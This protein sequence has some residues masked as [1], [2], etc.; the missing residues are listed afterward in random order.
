M[1]CNNVKA[2]SWVYNA[3]ALATWFVVV[4]TTMFMRRHMK[5]FMARRIKWLQEMPAPRSTT[6][7]VEG[8]PDGL[9]KEEALLK[10]FDDSVFARK[11]VKEV[12]VVKDLRHS[13]LGELHKNLEAMNRTIDYR[14]NAPLA[15]PGGS[16]AGEVSLIDLQ[17]TRKALEA[18]I[19][20]QR[21]LYVSDD[22]VNSNS[23][24]VTFL[25]EREAAVVLR[26]L[27]KAQHEEMVAHLPPDPGDVI[28][29]DLLQGNVER[30]WRSATGHVMLIMLF[31]AFIPITAFIAS[32]SRITYL[33][34][35]FK[36]V[37]DFRE[38]HKAI[39]VGWDAVVGG[40]ALQLMMGFL[41]TIM[42]LIART[43]YMPK[44]GAWLQLRIQNWS[45]G[46]T[47]NH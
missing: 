46:Y 22:E 2:G 14:R 44:S 33:A 12:F 15:P 38:R 28:W 8:L 41:P 6:V 30:Q 17:V 47:S 35:R 43:F 19:E 10:Y 34:D 42:S 21:S 3:D 23:A 25:R 9:N 27:D 24:F 45:S 16:K 1:S 7:L 11:A 40:L 13:G 20:K 29:E 18:Q 32:I 26:L 39:A 31:F 37:Q 36:V 5:Q 4:T